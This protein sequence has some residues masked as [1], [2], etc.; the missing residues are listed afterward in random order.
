M[1]LRR[2][3]SILLILTSL[4]GMGIAQERV[5]VRPSDLVNSLDN[6]PGWRFGAEGALANPQSA[7]GVPLSNCST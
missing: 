5:T 4:I 2:L 1:V 3:A 6:L 7:G